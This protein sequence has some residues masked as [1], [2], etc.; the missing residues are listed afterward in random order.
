MKGNELIFKENLFR[1]KIAFDTLTTIQIASPKAPAFLP[2]SGTLRGRTST[3]PTQ[4]LP[5]FVHFSLQKQSDLVKSM[6]YTISLLENLGGLSRFLWLFGI[7]PIKL[8][9]GHHKIIGL[10]KLTTHCAEIFQISRAC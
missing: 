2:T 3:K 6:P 4:C 10:L 9:R 5:S 7:K 1:N 8:Q